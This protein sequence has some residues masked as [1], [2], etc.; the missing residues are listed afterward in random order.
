MSEN[1]NLFAIFCNREALA[2]IGTQER[3]YL[4]RK[5]KFL[6]KQATQVSSDRIDYEKEHYPTVTK[7]QKYQGTERIIIFSNPFVLSVFFTAFIFVSNT[8]KSA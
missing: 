3:E 7:Y 8:L 1:P 2:T 6:P 5:S 4:R